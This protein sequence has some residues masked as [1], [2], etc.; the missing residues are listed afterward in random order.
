MSCVSQCIYER[1]REH[2]KN[3]QA[4]VDPSGGSSDSFTLAIAHR[5]TARKKVVVDCI[6]EFKPPFSP[7]AV[8]AEIAVT[9]KSYNVSVVWF[10]SPATCR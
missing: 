9:C 4:F 10:S 2:Y 8:C 1:G 5:D 7:E 6:R 3:Y